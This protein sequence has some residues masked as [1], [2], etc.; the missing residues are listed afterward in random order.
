MSDE[1]DEI[2]ETNNEISEKK[3]RGI[4]AKKLREARRI[5]REQKMEKTGRNEFAN[6]SYFELEDF[7]PA[8][9]DAFDKAGLTDLISFSKEFARME[10]IDDDGN[11]L[12]IRSP[13]AEANLRGCHPIQNAGAVQS[14]QRRYLWMAAMDIVEK[15]PIDSSKPV[16]ESKQLPAAEVPQHVAS[17]PIAGAPQTWKAVIA[18]IDKTA[19]EKNGKPWTRYTI[20]TADNRRAVTFDG[21]IG[22]AIL[23]AWAGDMT[24]PY[25]IF[26]KPNPNPRRPGEFLYTGFE[27]VGGAEQQDLVDL[28]PQYD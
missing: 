14:Y 10:I 20:A 8:C 12:E 25:K 27:K 4:V 1:T 15:D 26:V 9:L 19:G 7:L 23:A 21:K 18:D 11:Q 28:E 16:E 22:D 5:F 3:A 6:Y 17:A 2:N 13:M 24:R